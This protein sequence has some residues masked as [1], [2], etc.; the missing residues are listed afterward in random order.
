MAVTR[1]R[2]STWTRRE[3][4]LRNSR[5]TVS[6]ALATAELVPSFES[7]RLGNTNDFN[8]P[9]RVEIYPCMDASISTSCWAFGAMGDFRLTAYVNNTAAGG[10]SK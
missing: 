5:W 8:P 10:D 1:A 4:G 6:G 3:A 7:S 2:T 9:K